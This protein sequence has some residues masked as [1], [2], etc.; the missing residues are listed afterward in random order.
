MK[1][2]LEEIDRATTEAQLVAT[3][4][5]LCSLYSPRELSPL[6][7]DCRV[8]RIDG[9]ADIPRWREKLARTVAQ[10][11]DRAESP[12]K[13]DDLVQCFEHASQR[14]GTLRNPA[15]VEAANG[16]GYV[17]AGAALAD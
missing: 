3:T 15:P 12:A 16:P 10:A 1:S 6:P 14:L 11:R 8:I 13:L 5:D 17:N 4:R 9:G 7:E 2:W